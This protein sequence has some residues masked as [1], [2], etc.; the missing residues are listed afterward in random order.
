MAQTDRKYLKKV[1]VYVVTATVSLLFIAYIIYHLWGEYNTEVST[2]A[3]EYFTMEQSLTVDAYILRD[4][5]VLYADTAGTVDYAYDDGDKVAAGDRVA[6]VYADGEVGSK[7]IDIDSR[8]SILE[9]S[10][11]DSSVVSDTATIDSKIDGVYYR[12]LGK[13]RG[14]DLDSAMSLTSDM[15]VLLN[16]RALITDSVESYEDAISALRSEREEVS[17]ASD[18]TEDIIT[19]SAGYFYSQTDGYEG[20]YSSRNIDD[21]QLDS[22]DMLANAMP[23]VSAYESGR[24]AVGKIVTDYRWYVVCAVSTAEYRTVSLDRDSYYAVFP[25]SDDR[26]VSMKLYKVVNPTDDDRVLL[27]FYSSEMPDGF[28]YSHNQTV[29]LIT[30]DYSGYKV[31]ASAVTIQ[32]GRKGVF[33]LDSS[34]VGFKEI[35]PLFERDGWIVCEERDVSD[36]SQSGRLSLYDFVITGGKN[37]YDGKKLQ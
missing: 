12:M 18:A 33:V 30:A 25:A 15:V 28:D 35:V 36:E 7:L 19:D 9:R 14:G 13:I 10:R 4:E 1:A 11:V 5:T 2:I 20:V 6:T 8:I 37:L 23:N 22:F 27:I 34:V 26:R 3:A 21:M 24:H 32:D 31:P 17:A 29:E 16:K